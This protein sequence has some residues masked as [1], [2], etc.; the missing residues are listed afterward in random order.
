VIF[1]NYDPSSNIWS[2]K[3][4]FGG[5][6]RRAAVG[7]G[8]NNYGFIGTGYDGDN[9]KKDFWKYEPITDT[10]L[11]LVGFG[12][13]KRRGATTF[14]INDKTY[15]GTGISN[16]LYIDDFWEFDSQTEVWSRLLDLNDD[17][18]YN[19]MRSNATG[20]AINNLGY[21]A[22]GYNNGT[23]GT[24]W[25]Y[26]PSTDDWEEI[27]SLEATIRQ[28]ATS[29]SNGSRA[30]VMLGRTGTLYLDDNYELFPLEEYD[31]DD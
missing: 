3:A 18:D 21:I 29:F 7:F 30:F 15:L 17:S 31:E 4:D 13:D 22:T 19:V 1:W 26:T 9:D 14:T 25:E 11:E 23:T 8:A 16:G 5:G 2:Q 12:G 24:I 20:F 27:T 10:W 28:D 6:I